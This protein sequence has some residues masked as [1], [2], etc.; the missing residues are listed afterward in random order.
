[1]IKSAYCAHTMIQN[2]NKVLCVYRGPY[3][4]RAVSIIII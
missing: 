3:W 2:V 1:M 4:V